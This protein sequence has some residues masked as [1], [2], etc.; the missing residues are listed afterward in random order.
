MPRK[1]PLTK[2]CTTTFF[3]QSCSWGDKTEAH[4]WAVADDVTAQLGDATVSINSYREVYSSGGH[5]D[6]PAHRT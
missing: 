1:V 2:D 4:M 5:T 3:P 6:W